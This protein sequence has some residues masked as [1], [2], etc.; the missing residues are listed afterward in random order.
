MEDAITGTDVGEE[1]V[2]KSLSFVSSLHQTS[3]VRNVEKSWNLAKK[4]KTARQGGIISQ[5]EIHGCWTQFNQLT[6][7]TPKWFV[8]LAEEVIALIW[9]RHPAL[10]WVDCAEREVLC[11]S[12]AFGQHVEKGGLPE[13]DRQESVK[14]SATFVHSV[15]Q[16][17]HA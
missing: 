4:D 11:S 16:H 3:N 15:S 8:V 5:T 2:S 1:G 14:S 12:Q 6:E 7:H 9:N 13:D 10:I 17:T